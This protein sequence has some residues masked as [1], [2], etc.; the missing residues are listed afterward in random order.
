MS[1]VASLE[2]GTYT[3]KKKQVINSLDSWKMFIYIIY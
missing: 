3:T 1:E 2:L